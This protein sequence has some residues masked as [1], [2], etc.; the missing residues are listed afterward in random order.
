MAADVWYWARGFFPSR[1]GSKLL[2]SD[3]SGKLHIFSIHDS[4]TSNLDRSW[5]A[6]DLEIW[7]CAWSPWED[8]IFWSG[9]AYNSGRKLE[10]LC[11]I[12][13]NVSVWPLFFFT[14][15]KD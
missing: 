6:H 14:F 5:R 4:T 2:A 8:H 9:M 10:N 3:T 11:G 7:T 15:A 12:F 13:P 1:S